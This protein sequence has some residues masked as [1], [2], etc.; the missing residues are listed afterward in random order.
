MAT[1][2]DQDYEHCH[3][4][5]G[6]GRSYIHISIVPDI[7]QGTPDRLAGE[8][9]AMNPLRPKNPTVGIHWHITKGGGC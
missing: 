9:S 5:D 6:H 1:G 8:V 3:Y 4:E 2:C 7:L